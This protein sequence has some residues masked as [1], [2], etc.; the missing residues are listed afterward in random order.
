MMYYDIQ[1]FDYV[2]LGNSFETFLITEKGKDA[3]L[4]IEGTI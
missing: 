3:P 4:K 1:L 2:M